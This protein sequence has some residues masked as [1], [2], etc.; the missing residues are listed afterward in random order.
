M[1]L[2]SRALARANLHPKRPTGRRLRDPFG[3]PKRLPTGRGDLQRRADVRSI[4][5][6]AVQPS[7]SMAETSLAE[8]A[9]NACSVP[10][11]TARRRVSEW[12]DREAARAR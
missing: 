5:P 6:V 2:D 10:D 4:K 3:I 1:T 9:M 8:P 12:R 7:I 11:T